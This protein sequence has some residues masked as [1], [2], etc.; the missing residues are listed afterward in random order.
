MVAVPP[1][2]AALAA[3]DEGDEASNLA[4][5]GGGS[6]WA[7]HLAALS[8]SVPVTPRDQLEITSRVHD[9]LRSPLRAQVE[10]AQAEVREAE[11]VRLRKLRARAKKVRQRMAATASSLRI[12]QLEQLWGGP[13][14]AQGSKRTLKLLGELATLASQPN[15]DGAE[16]CAWELCRLLETGRERDL[17]TVRTQGGLESLVT[18]ALIAC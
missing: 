18:L 6:T 11:R 16:T 7:S 1:T 2:L 13:G 12:E 4:T 9:L 15:C 17:H 10:A 14:S 5:S 3:K 8:T